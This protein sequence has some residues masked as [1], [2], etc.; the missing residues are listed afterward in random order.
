M[1]TADKR[2]ADHLKRIGRQVMIVILENAQDSLPPEQ[3]AETHRRCQELTS[4]VDS[5]KKLHR[6]SEVCQ[7]KTGETLKIGQPAVSETQKQEDMYLFA[8]HGQVEVL[9]GGL[10]PVVRSPNRKQ[11]KVKS[12]DVVES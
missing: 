10:D 12:P 1:G 5:L 4:E 2:Y 11:V 7:V 8:L 9:G 3:R 6:L